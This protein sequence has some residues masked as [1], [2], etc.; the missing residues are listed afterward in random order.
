MTL[1]FFIDNVAHLLPYMF[2]LVAYLLLS[3]ESE[4]VSRRVFAVSSVTLLLLFVGLRGA[5]TP[6]M[7]RYMWMYQDP[8]GSEANALEPSFYVFSH[9]LH[10]LGLDYH[11]MFFCYTFVTFIFLYLGIRSQTS[12]VRMALLLYILLPGYFLNLF[13]EMREMCAV[14]I[15]FYAIAVFRRKHMRFRLPIFFSLAALSVAFHFSALL[16]WA[17]FLP[18]YGFIRKPHSSVC[19]LALIGGGLAVPTSF[20]IKGISLVAMPVVPGRYQ[21]YI[22]AFLRFESD[23]TESGQLLKT[24]IYAA[25]AVCFIFWWRAKDSE[26]VDHVPLNLFVIGVAIL[27]LTRSFAAA[28]R[29]S[30][31]FVIYQIILVPG[32][33]HRVRDRVMK[34]LA[35]YGTV[36]FYLVQFSYGLFFY[37]VEAGNYPYLHYQ[38]VLLSVFK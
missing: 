17:V 11:A 23:Q 10:A 30:Y 33:L 21:A 29:L 13:V 18:A 4:L 1:Q 3:L 6:D 12:H 8:N 27:G 37:S 19:Y 28:S 38:N 9:V 31:F 20:L 32:I 14:A 25:M 34:L 15:A 7:Q 26:E 16:F 35:A 22:E 5:M 24:L 2:L 36:L